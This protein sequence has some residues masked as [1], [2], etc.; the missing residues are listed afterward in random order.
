[1][2]DLHPLEIWYTLAGAEAGIDTDPATPLARA[3]V[4]LMEMHRQL[5]SIRLAFISNGPD[6][7][8]QRWL[9]LFARSPGGRVLFVPGVDVAL[10]RVRGVEGG[11]ERFDRQFD[12]DHVSLEQDR[13]TWHITSARSEVHQGGPNAL[14][15]GENRVLWFGM[16]IRDPS[17][18][19]VARQRT[20]AKYLVDDAAIRHKLGQLE[21]AIDGGAS[22]IVPLAPQPV[23]QRSFPL[24]SVVVGPTGFQPYRGPEWGAPYGSTFVS[25]EPSPDQRFSHLATQFPLDDTTDIFVATTWIPGEM[26][27]PMILTTPMGSA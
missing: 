1:M 2:T 21:R 24:L 16:A 14:E 7:P 3:L 27:I 15:I 26:A 13:D 17:V 4:P 8:P 6:Q 12:L 10:S 23:D 22:V 25:G 5:P 18:L 20:C 19:R 11:A 9:G